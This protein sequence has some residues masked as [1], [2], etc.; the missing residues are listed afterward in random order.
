MQGKI[1][2]IGDIHGCYEKLILLLKRIPFDPGHDTLVFLGDYFDRGPDTRRVMDHLCSLRQD[3]VRIIPL[4]GNHEH[5]ILEYHKT[6]DHALIPYLR[7]LGV[8]SAIKSYGT[9]DLAQLNSL[10][11]LPVEH[12]TFLSSLLPFWETKEL[13]FVHA[14]LRHNRPLAE[15]TISDLCECREPF[16]SSTVDYGKRVIFGHTPFVTPFV[17]PNKIGIDTGAVYGNLL[18]AIEL[19]AIRF[20]HA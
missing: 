7:Q 3:G 14:G 11:F 17:T 15:Q 16:I 2:A 19:P 8:E 5:L 12:M 6:H 20:Y 10:S 4:I 13:L 18:T 1:F 9:G